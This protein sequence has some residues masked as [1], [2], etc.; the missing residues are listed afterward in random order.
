VNIA[1]KCFS[2]INQI[3]E[4]TAQNNVARRPLGNKK[5]SGNRFVFIVAKCFIQQINRNGRG[6]A[7]IVHGNVILMPTK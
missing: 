2:V 4:N 5:K 1:G 3:R 7:I 6:T